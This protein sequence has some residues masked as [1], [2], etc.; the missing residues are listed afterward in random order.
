MNI[1]RWQRLLVMASVVMAYMVRAEKCG[2]ANESNDY[3]ETGRSYL[4]ARQLFQS[5]SPEMNAGFRDDR[6]HAR[7]DGH[8]LTYQLVLFGGKSDDNDKIRRY[9]TPFG[10]SQLIVDEQIL[11]TITTGKTQNL[12]AAHFNI[13]TVNGDYRSVIEFH[14]KQT[15][16]GLG[17]HFRGDVWQ[18]VEDNRAIWVSASTP[19]THVNNTF[20]IQETVINDGGG[21]NSAVP[22]AVGSMLEAYRQ[23]AWHYGRI[24]EAGFNETGSCSTV[25]SMGKTALADIELKVGIEWLE[26]HPCHFESYLGVKVPTGNRPKGVFIF[27]PIV[28]NGGHL[29]AMFGTSGGARIWDWEEC[30]YDLRLE[31]AIHSEYV[32]SRNQVRSLDLKN[33]PYTR[34][35]Q[36][37]ANEQQAL[38]AAATENENLFT[39]GINLLT[40]PVKVTPGYLFDINSAFVFSTHKGFQGEV[41]YNLY[42]RK[43][44]NVKLACPFVP[45]PAIKHW[46]GQGYTNPV[47]DITG[48][49]RLEDNQAGGPSLPDVAP[50]YYAANRIKES[51]LDLASCAQP[52]IM[53]HTLYVSAGKR[54]DE[55]EYPVFMNLGGSG[56]F[57]Q[58]NNAALERW[59]LWGK[60]GMSF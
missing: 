59:V 55:R 4:S 12:L 9:F 22:G 7:E 49:F 28:G 2:V 30:G 29:A 43:S 27:E 31:Y 46:Y 21:V 33:K 18:S 26:R 56:E 51:D 39:P 42:Y 20:A 38:L 32:F 47:R 34:Y 24:T 45:G 19:L 8:G 16:V 13:F 58:A 52:A 6:M 53:T 15:T 1:K 37:Y 10:L 17:F 40:L 50:Q 54:W 36:L 44:D 35:I 41:G 3:D 48:N 25:H 11:N 5:Q 60:F 23:P 57:S 14:P